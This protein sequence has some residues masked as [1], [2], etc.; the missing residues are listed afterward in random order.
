MAAKTWAEFCDSD[1]DFRTACNEAANAADQ[2]LSS[3]MIHRIKRSRDAEKIYA[4][5]IQAS[6]WSSAGQAFTWLVGQPQWRTIVLEE[7]AAARREAD[8]RRTAFDWLREWWLKRSPDGK[9]STAERIASAAVISVVGT[10][11]AAT[12][13]LTVKA[14]AK[15]ALILPVRLEAPKDPTAVPFAV[16]ATIDSNASPVRI[17]LDTAGTSATIPIKVTVDPANA[18][19]KIVADQGGA[20]EG[21]TKAIAGVTDAVNVSNRKMGPEL[22]RDVV[23]IQDAIKGIKAFDP[24]ASANIAELGKKLSCDPAQ[25][26]ALSAVAQ[27]FVD[28]GDDVHRIAEFSAPGRTITTAAAIEK[29]R[30]KI[31]ARWTGPDG[32]LM[33][34]ATEVDAGKIGQWLHVG[35]LQATC[36]PG[37]P[38][39][40]RDLDLNVGDVVAIGDLL[41]VTVDSISRPAFAK[42]SARLRVLTVPVADTVVAKRASQP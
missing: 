32:K 26:K 27:K 1:L 30:T 37:E 7:I 15:D 5:H 38:V 17:A 42:N 10:A 33:S 34:C 36:G 16:T 25:V 31:P 40:L 20:V 11:G 3:A 21:I 12:T 13:Y 29:H 39:R 9:P 41:A 14:V 19:L 4:R 23:G 6:P 22:H 18:P 8:L 2:P 35:T 24:N 28:V